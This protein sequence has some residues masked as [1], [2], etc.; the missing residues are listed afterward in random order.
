MQGR[1]RKFQVMDRYWNQRVMASARERPSGAGVDTG[2][3]YAP[4]GLAE[5]NRDLFRQASAWG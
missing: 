1:D 2:G 4:S 5:L 3:S